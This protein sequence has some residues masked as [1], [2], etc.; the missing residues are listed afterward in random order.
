[1]TLRIEPYKLSSRGAKI[2]ADTLGVL[3]ATPRQVARHGTFDKVINW[4]MSERRFTDC[5]YINDPRAVQMASDKLETAK[6]LSEH[7]IP[8]PDWTDNRD[9]VREWL[10]GGNT[11]LCRT[12]LRASQG[13]GIV[14]LDPEDGGEIPRAPLYTKYIRK[15]DEYRIHV[16]RDRIISQQM[17]RRNKDVPDDRVNWQIRNHDNGFVFC[18]GAV[19]APA[20]VKDTSINA[21]SALGLDFGAVDIGY[22][23]RRDKCRVYEVNTAPGLEGTTAD[24]YRSAFLELLPELNAG[25]YQRRRNNDA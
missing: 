1:M 15:T 16:C 6:V 4:G 9:V 13:R 10:D 8:Q 22:N 20:C 3:R 23:A 5:E 18:R 21:V 14:V 25:A 2:L 19:D 7:G 17:K 11:V 12:L 24:H